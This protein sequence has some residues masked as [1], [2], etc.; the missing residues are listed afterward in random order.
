MSEDS[1]N[2]TDPQMQKALSVAQFSPEVLE[3]ISGIVRVRKRRQHEAKHSI[4]QKDVVR[5]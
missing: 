3:F 2:D 5:P 1:N 4:S